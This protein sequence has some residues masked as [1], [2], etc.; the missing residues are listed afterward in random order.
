MKM[1][2]PKKGKR[3]Q[4]MERLQLL[5]EKSKEL[6]LPEYLTEERRLLLKSLFQCESHQE[7]MNILLR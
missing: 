2:Q 4:Q 3:I 7:I 1:I 6:W 5:N